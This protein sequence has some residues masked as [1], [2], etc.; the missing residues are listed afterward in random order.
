MKNLILGLLTI[1]STII[2]YSFQKIVITNYKQQVVLIDQVPIVNTAMVILNDGTNNVQ[3]FQMIFPTEK[4]DLIGQIDVEDGF[5]NPLTYEITDS[6]MDLA[7]K[8][9]QIKFTF[10]NF[11][12]GDALG[13]TREITINMRVYYYGKYEF[14]P[15]YTDLFVRFKYLIILG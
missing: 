12:L 2:S 15:A 10:I 3:D 8:D 11:V 6:D 9:K 1:I 13:P 14:L 7:I 5:G 4:I